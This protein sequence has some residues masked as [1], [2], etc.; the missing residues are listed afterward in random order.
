M[1]SSTASF[2]SLRVRGVAWPMLQSPLLSPIRLSDV[3]M[4][5][6]ALFAK[7]RTGEETATGPVYYLQS[8]NGNL[9]E[10]YAVLQKDVGMDG[11]AFAR[12]VFGT[13]LCVFLQ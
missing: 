3:N 4:S 5:L 13:F 1:R 10:E 11:P 6:D 12:E 2:L 7:L 9:G 8:Q